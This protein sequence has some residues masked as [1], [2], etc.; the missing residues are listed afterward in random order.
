MFIDTHCHL[1]LSE[2]DDDIDAVIQRAHQEDIRK[3]YLPAIDSSTHAKLLGVE[4]RFPGSCI[5][6]M[7]LHPTSVKEN[8]EEELRIVEEWLQQRKFAAL[9]EIGLPSAVPIRREI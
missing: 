3:F 8:Y 2:F 4:S 9:G 1:Y 5:A 7:G 6:M